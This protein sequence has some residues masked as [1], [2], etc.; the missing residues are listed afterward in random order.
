ML[1][2]Y[3]E[4]WVPMTDLNEEMRQRRALIEKWASADQAFRDVRHPVKL[5]SSPQEHH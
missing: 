3:Q 2:F 5:I 1:L 4:E